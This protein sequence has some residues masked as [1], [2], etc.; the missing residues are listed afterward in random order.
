MT[1]YSP[2]YESLRDLLLHFG[3]PTA[4]NDPDHVCHEE[5][6]SRLRAIGMICRLPDNRWGMSDRGVTVHG[7]LKKG[8]DCREN[9]TTKDWMAPG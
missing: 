6:V 4:A 5:D 3:S 7:M 2:T 1:N 9:L 8:V